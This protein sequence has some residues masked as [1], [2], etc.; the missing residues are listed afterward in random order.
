MPSPRHRPW[1][2]GRAPAQYYEYFS[3]SRAR[4]RELALRA[5][6]EHDVSLR[7]RAPVVQLLVQ[8][9]DERVKVDARRLLLYLGWV[10]EVFGVCV[11]H[12]L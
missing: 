5:A 10:T 7:L 12:G 6:L 2:D 4:G 9:L 1:D 3:L 8:G 11:L